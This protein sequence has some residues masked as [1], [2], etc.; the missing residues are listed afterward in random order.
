MTDKIWDMLDGQLSAEEQKALQR[1]LATLP[2]LQ[3]SYEEAKTLDEE[4]KQMEAD[5]PSMRF[6]KNLFEHL[7]T[8]YKKVK[9][10]ANISKRARRIGLFVLSS[11]V[12]FSFLPAFMGGSSSYES[13]YKSL[14]EQFT[15]WSFNLPNELL[16]VLF[17]VG[18]S[19][20]FFL[21]LDWQ[22]KR[23]FFNGKHRLK[24]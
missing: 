10:D 7:P 20:T 2:E 24:K 1:D 9:I 21:L 13:P 15:A 3:Q 5:E 4:L 14:W 18:I 12:V 19:S 16:N 17:L 22:L 8:L 6:S 11:L 23:R